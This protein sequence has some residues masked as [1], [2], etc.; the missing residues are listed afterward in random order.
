M[1]QHLPMF[2]S[3]A[4]LLLSFPSFGAA[5]HLTLGHVASQTTNVILQD[6]ILIFQL[7]MVRLDS[8]DTFGESLKGRLE[9]L[10]L[11]VPSASAY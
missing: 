6:L 10:G 4:P 2:R 9:G 7:V 1:M 5:G 11:S 3:M 8:I